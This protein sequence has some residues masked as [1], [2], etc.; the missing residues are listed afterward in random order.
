MLKC[1][2]CESQLIWQNDFDFEDY[3]IK[4]Q[5]IVGV[6]L[7]THCGAFHLL[8]MEAEKGLTKILVA[9]EDDEEAEELVG[10]NMTKVIGWME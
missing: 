3:G 9:Q 4:G 1:S 6:Y 7:C 10:D 2:K 8:H 5:G